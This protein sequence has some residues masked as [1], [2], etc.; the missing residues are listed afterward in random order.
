[1]LD[2]VLGHKTELLCICKHGKLTKLRFRRLAIEDS[3][4]MYS[5]QTR[6]KFSQWELSLHR[7]SPMTLLGILYT[8]LF[9]LCVYDT[10]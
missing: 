8:R 3:I 9:E 7:S 10:L 2:L 6:Q 4:H 5:V 1:M